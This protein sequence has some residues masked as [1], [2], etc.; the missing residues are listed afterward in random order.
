MRVESGLCLTMAT[1]NVERLK[2]REERRLRLTR[3][4]GLGLRPV[5]GEGTEDFSLILEI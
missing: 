1:G 3:G 5:K 4:K 2:L